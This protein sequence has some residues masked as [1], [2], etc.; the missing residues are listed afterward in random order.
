MKLII[1]GTVPDELLN[2]KSDLIKAI[3][4]KNCDVI[5]SSSPL[6]ANSKIDISSLDFIYEPIHLE[7][8]GFSLIGNIRTIISLLNLYKKYKPQYILAF[9]I[10]LVIWGGIS[11]RI[12]NASFPYITGLGYAFQGKSLP[13][14]FLT[15]LVSFLYKIALKK[16]K[17]VIFENKDNRDFFVSKK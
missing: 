16:S 12:R 2:L 14:K 5:A 15:K 6:I 1:L 17:A 13:R 11:A 7:R 9:G 4:K 8:H 10:K 3:I